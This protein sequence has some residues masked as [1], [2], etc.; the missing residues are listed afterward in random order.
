MR[1]RSMPDKSQGA[2]PGAA[3]ED[4]KGFSLILVLLVMVLLTAMGL[5]LMFTSET[6]HAISR[7]YTSAIQATYAAEAG[8][9]AA[10]QGFKYDLL[11][12][13][14][15][16]ANRWLVIPEPVGG[17]NDCGSG[18][19]DAVCKDSN[20]SIT[21][22]PDQFVANL[23]PWVE[24]DPADDN[25]PN[26]G[27]PSATEFP[28]PNRRAEF[29]TKLKPFVPWLFGDTGSGTYYVAIRSIYD[30]SNNS[31]VMQSEL[32]IIAEGISALKV[33]SNITSDP[34]SA[35][36]RKIEV[37]IF[38]NNTD[39]WGNALVGGKE[40]EGLFRVH[41][42]VLNFNDTA[43]KTVFDFDTPDTGIYNTITPHK[44]SNN[45]IDIP[46][47][48]KLWLG[49]S[50]IRDETAACGGSPPSSDFDCIYSQNHIKPPDD[51]W[52]ER[53]DSLP[54]GD[55]ENMDVT[56]R[57]KKG[58]VKIS[59]TNAWIGVSYAPPDSND[60][61]RPSQ[62]PDNTHKNT[63]A[64]FLTN[65][66]W[67]PTNFPG[68]THLK[69][70]LVADFDFTDPDFKFP[71]LHDIHKTP[72]GIY[73]S[74]MHYIHNDA[75][76]EA[77]RTTEDPA[78]YQ[79]ERP[80][81]WA[82]DLSGLGE[83]TVPP[84]PGDTPNLSVKT[85]VLHTTTA[86][87]DEMKRAERYFFVNNRTPREKLEALLDKDP[88]DFPTYFTELP[89]VPLTAKAATHP[90]DWPAIRQAV[91]A[92]FQNFNC[93]MTCHGTY[94]DGYGDCTCS[95]AGWS[96][97]NST[98]DV[99]GDV[100]GMHFD[101]RGMSKQTGPGGAVGDPWR[102]MAAAVMMDILAPRLNGNA[103]IPCC[104]DDR[105][106]PATDPTCCSSC[107]DVSKSKLYV[108]NIGTAPAMY[109]DNGLRLR[110]L[111]HLD[112]L[113]S[114]QD[115][116]DLER[117]SGDSTYRAIEKDWF[118]ASSGECT[119]AGL[120]CHKHD[121][122]RSYRADRWIGAEITKDW[123]GELKFFSR[124][125]KSGAT[126]VDMPVLL[127]N[128][129]TAEDDDDPMND[130]LYTD[131]DVQAVG[132]RFHAQYLTGTQLATCAPTYTIN[133][134]FHDMARDPDGGWV[135]VTDL[136]IP[137]MT[138]QQ[139]C[140]DFD[141]DSLGNDPGA[142]LWEL[143]G[144][145]RCFCRIMYQ[146]D[147]KIRHDRLDS[148][149]NPHRD[150]F[151]WLTRDENAPT[152]HFALMLYVPADDPFDLFDNM[153][154]SPLKRP[155]DYIYDIDFS[156]EGSP[157]KAD[158]QRQPD[159]YDPSNS[160]D[161]NQADRFTPA[162]EAHLLVWAP[163]D[164]QVSTQR[165]GSGAPPATWYAQQAGQGNTMPYAGSDPEYIKI[166]RRN[167]I[168]PCTEYYAA[169]CSGSYNEQCKCFEYYGSPDQSPWPKIEHHGGTQNLV[170]AYFVRETI[171]RMKAGWSGAF[172]SNQNLDPDW[173]ITAFMPTSRYFN[174]YFVN[175]TTK[176]DDLTDAFRWD[177][178]WD[179]LGSRST[180]INTGSSPGK[181]MQQI[182]GFGMLKANGVILTKT[183]GITFGSSNDNL[184][185][186][187]SDPNDYSN[188]VVTDGR[189][190]LV[191]YNDTSGT[192]SNP[193]GTQSGDV[194]YYDHVAPI[195]RYGCEDFSATIAYSDTRVLNSRATLTSGSPEKTRI[196]MYSFS[197]GGLYVNDTADNSLLA[198]GS[199]LAGAWLADKANFGTNGITDLMGLG[200]DITPGK[201]CDSDHLPRPEWV[202]VKPRSFAEQQF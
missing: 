182:G 35:S 145:D 127:T 68:E 62:T 173:H 48:D 185:A 120:D 108:N 101:N 188:M 183:G 198:D 103:S 193:D 175:T 116:R 47:I 100:Y 176:E 199:S 123:K 143:G 45:S 52:D 146:A 64:R 9:H 10:M 106:C 55:P 170:M 61:E 133:C 21:G 56:V 92:H 197:E 44:M 166:P 98:R 177:G 83:G 136:T 79:A 17:V 195:G 33:K 107:W 144:V 132:E 184:R 15:Y 74:Y 43:T 104:W 78:T 128:W 165:T 192:W 29:E 73:N 26:C 76:L 32:G 148:S 109:R 91:D 112:G 122:V 14:N 179:L 87:A 152:G 50:Q 90:G 53:N 149:N 80:S 95:G 4:D 130:L 5:T 70:D 49:E 162:G 84:N 59:N 24:S 102:S 86:L 31:L 137:P 97:L 153:N 118:D 23:C 135:D 121:G 139:E 141:D 178:Y 194:V 27:F 34:A 18:N 158:F 25:D 71:S 125:W 186:S 142:C 85:E 147:T 6:E 39:P 65:V 36:R 119:V 57:I 54:S 189:F 19:S 124:P 12:D 187:T 110:V 67:E 41:G 42:N 115:Y 172:F 140:W 168:K 1:K 163:V 28:P 181:G 37:T 167:M 38:G 190:I 191:S 200:Y 134:P 75:S 16:W 13:E 82:M 151:Y 88:A 157:D 63:I 202:F 2:A 51:F 156:N 58:V 174:A 111:V 161:W 155:A 131:M 171:P 93:E 159:S 30:P 196:A 69:A 81:I 126:P 180:T 99:G 117:P 129:T 22:I 114:Y 3:R 46:G 20:G 8:V 96:E 160:N 7:N 89:T 94:T 11:F 169:T 113:K 154:T 40:A 77:G 150:T 60:L 201:G 164:F 105:E 138:T 72:Y 66:T